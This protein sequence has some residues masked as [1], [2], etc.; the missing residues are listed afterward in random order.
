MQK[1]A[2]PLFSLLLICYYPVH[3]F[4]QDRDILVKKVDALP[5]NSSEEKL[6]KATLQWALNE[7][8]MEE[9]AGNAD[10]VQGLLNDVEVSIN[11]KIGARQL[12]P[13]NI[14][15]LMPKFEQNTIAQSAVKDMDKLIAAGISTDPNSPINHPTGVADY[16]NKLGPQ[17]LLLAEA[18]CHPQSP[19]LGDPKAVALMF[20]IFEVLFHNHMPGSKLL[21]D[22]GHSAIMT[23]MYLMVKTVYPDLIL[24]SRQ[25]NWELSIKSNAD[26]IM[27]MRSNLFKEGKS[28]TAYPNADV[29]Y[30]TALVYSSMVLNDSQYQETALA[31]E[32]L[33][34]SAIYPDGGWAYIGEQNENYTYHTINISETCRLFQLTG[35]LIAKKNIEASRWYLPLSIEPPGVAEYA[36]APGWKHYWNQIKGQ[37]VA[38]MLASV[39]NDPQ[40]MRI[41]KF[42]VP[43]PDFILASYYRDDIIAAPTP[44]NYFVYD[45]NI[46]GPRGRFGNYSFSGTSRNM[47][48]EDRG[49]STN[50]GAMMLYPRDKLP[51]SIQ[52]GY[53]LNAALD[54]AGTEI[55]L[56]PGGDAPVELSRDET[57]AVTVGRDVAAV[58]TN[59]RISPYHGTVTNFTGQQAWLYTP[60]RIVGL[61]KVTSL[62]DQDVFGVNGVISFLSVKPKNVE[63]RQYQVMANNTFE[64][65]PFITQIHDHNYGRIIQTYATDRLSDAT[66]KLIDQRATDDKQMTALHYSQNESHYYLAEIRPETS[67]P[68]TA[69]KKID[70]GNGLIAF[71]LVDADK[72]YRLIYNPTVTDITYQLKVQPGLK[73]LYLHSSGEE[74][75]PA[76]IGSD[77]KET[78]INGPTIIKPSHNVISVVIPA[79]KHVVLIN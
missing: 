27:K 31:G 16:N 70:T 79:G 52:P 62:K 6:K 45:R 12:A 33:M 44:D 63:I 56:K 22:F 40:N 21:G 76:W 14:F 69:V 71:E 53:P 47:P 1:C 2:V 24:P 25:K 29:K 61:V 11:A 35:D 37:E 64:Y 68:A 65:G 60:Q 58:T 13:T 55:L 5:V 57:N 54:I 8:Q 17:G 78:L 49:K 41:A 26:V 9:K 19:H 59:Y 48:H 66:I 4:A 7:A 42:D 43:K 30:I 73:Q 75:R 10:E 23:E 28:G 15:P 3:T 32:K 36:M 34:S 77:G 72:H 38:Y 39:L 51:R 20:H 74:Y 50:I 46:E 67:A 18:F